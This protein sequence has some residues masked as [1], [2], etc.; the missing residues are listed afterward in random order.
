MGGEELA[1]RFSLV[2]ARS[3]Y[4]Q[5]KFIIAPIVVESMQNNLLAAMNQKWPRIT[6]T[7]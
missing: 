4:A 2:L 6:T 5:S 7:S 3:L 1:R